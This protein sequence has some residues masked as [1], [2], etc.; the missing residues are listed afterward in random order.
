MLMLM[1]VMLRMVRLVKRKAGRLKSKL[2][3][4]DDVAVLRGVLLPLSFAVS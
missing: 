2:G 3:G 4:N 1:L